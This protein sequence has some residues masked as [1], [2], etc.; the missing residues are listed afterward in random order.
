MVSEEQRE[1]QS[2]P[3]KLEKVRSE[4]ET[5]YPF[6][7]RLAADESRCDLVRAWTTGYFG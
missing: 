6:F 4:K 1:A 5:F 3:A 7:R 2:D